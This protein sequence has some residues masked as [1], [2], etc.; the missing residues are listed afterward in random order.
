VKPTATPDVD[1][2]GFPVDAVEVGRI[3]GAWG[4]KGWIRVQPYARDPK[5]LFAAKHWFVAPAERPGPASAPSAPAVLRITASRSHG[6]EV[7]A[8]ASEL[9]DRAAAQA[10]RG[11]RVYVSRASFPRTAED[12]YYWVD[13]IGLEVVNREGQRLGRVT[14]LL[15]TGAHSVL[16]LR[17]DDDADADRIERLI[18]FVGAYIDSVDLESRRIVADWGLDY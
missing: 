11:A 3:A 7:V 2:P 10:L 15:D 1:E 14:D 5:A 9:H 8:V 16:K 17:P 12:E 6:D 18:P 13:L 4:V